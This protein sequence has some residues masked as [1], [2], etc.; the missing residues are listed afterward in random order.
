MQCSIVT[1]CLTWFKIFLKP[2][3]N[4][5]EKIPKNYSYVLCLFQCTYEPISNSNILKCADLIKAAFL[6]EIVLINATSTWTAAVHNF[7]FPTWKASFHRS[8][9]CFFTC[10]HFASSLLLQMFMFATVKFKIMLL[11]SLSTYEQYLI[12]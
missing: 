10:V 4:T 8:L 12:K 11:L 2:N 9:L 7:Q 5:S 6:Q 3:I 1:Y